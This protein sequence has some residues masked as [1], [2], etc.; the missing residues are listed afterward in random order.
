MPRHSTGFLARLARTQQVL[1]LHCDPGVRIGEFRLW[2]FN[3]PPFVFRIHLGRD[4]GYLLVGQT[5]MVTEMIEN[6]TPSGAE[7]FV[8]EHFL[9]LVIRAH[10]IRPR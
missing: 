1:G 3:E 9:C 2:L 10:F 5:N 6:V 7:S 4:E 8:R